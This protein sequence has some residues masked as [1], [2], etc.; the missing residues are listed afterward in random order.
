MKVRSIV[1]T[2]LL[3]TLGTAALPAGAGA[4]GPIA[5]V[6]AAAA[7]A[8]AAALLSAGALPTSALPGAVLQTAPLLAAAPSLAPGASGSHIVALQKALIARGHSIPAGPT[9]YYGS[10]TRAAVAAFQ[11]S[12]GWRGSGADGIPGPQTL[13][14]LGLSRSAPAAASP[15]PRTVA[16]PAARAPAVSAGSSGDYR[17]GASGSHVVALQKA[18]I[19]RGHRIPAGPTGYYGSQTRAAVAAFQRSQGWRGSGA[20][21]I[22][23]R[24]TLARLGAVA[25]SPAARSV[26]APSGALS[27]GSFIARYGPMARSAAAATGVPALVTL[28]QAALESGWG[29]GAA[30]N[31]F[32]GVKAKPWESG[33]ML[34]TTYEV[35]SSPDAKG[36]AQILSV[37]RRAD[38]RYTYQVRDW[39]RTYASAEESFVQ[40]NQLLRGSRYSGAFRHTADP[41]RFASAVAAAGYATDPSYTNKVHDVMRLI[42]RYG[43]R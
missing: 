13:A 37:T 10:Q 32:F 24:Q 12:Q 18:L 14:R 4:A 35:L 25:S 15:A 26:A 3:G 5:G 38:G 43:F 6:P 19:A 39:F 21:G 23:G 41:Y 34:R 29:R 40:H 17:M 30:G 33:R 8:P 9:G 11:R 16:A 31:N 20:D 7:Q 28:G 2:C 42:E 1:A 22:P 36:F 27:P